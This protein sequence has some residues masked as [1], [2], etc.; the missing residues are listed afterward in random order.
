LGGWIRQSARD[1][2][3]SLLHDLGVGNH[4]GGERLGLG[5]VRGIAEGL[6]ILETGRVAAE[7]GAAAVVRPRLPGGGGNLALA[8]DE[9]KTVEGGAG[10]GALPGRELGIFVE[11]LD[12]DHVLQ[13]AVHRT[14]VNKGRVGLEAVLVH[15]VVRALVPKFERDAR[16]GRPNGGEEKVALAAHAVVELGVVQ[17]LEGAG[18]GHRLVDRV[19]TGNGSHVERLVLACVRR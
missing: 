9:A 14:A 1:L 18:G 8:L 5:A 11:I 19:G 4:D 16:D 13:A 15:P 7:A 6:S 12:A 10:G 17:L 3:P 2:D